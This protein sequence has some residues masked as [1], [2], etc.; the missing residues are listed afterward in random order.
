M[1][2]H[3]STGSVNDGLSLKTAPF[4]ADR[5]RLR[6]AETFHLN[7]PPLHDVYS[8]C[9]CTLK[10]NE[11]FLGGVCLTW[12]LKQ[13]YIR[14]RNIMMSRR[15]GTCT[16]NLPCFFEGGELE[17]AYRCG[18]NSVL[19]IWRCASC[20]CFSVTILLAFESGESSLTTNIRENMFPR[21]SGAT[22]VYS[23]IP[24]N[25]NHGF[26]PSQPVSKQYF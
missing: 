11:P 23:S 9:I 12:G 5:A 22:A 6:R 16:I 8:S 15:E 25:R 7:S 2:W 14:G 1:G 3:R 17:P 20:Y 13:M 10:P 4:N 26:W 21:S 19:W 18:K 24:G